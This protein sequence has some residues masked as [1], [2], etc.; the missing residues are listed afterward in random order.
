MKIKEQ[1]AIIHIENIFNMFNEPEPNLKFDIDCLNFT[2]S[3]TGKSIL[4]DEDSEEKGKEKE[5]TDIIDDEYIHNLLNEL[6]I[7]DK[8]LSEEYIA[9]SIER[10]N[11]VF[12]SK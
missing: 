12:S 9:K 4:E 6:K 10:Y 7:T 11:K 1:E 5:H 8:P 3:K 2:S